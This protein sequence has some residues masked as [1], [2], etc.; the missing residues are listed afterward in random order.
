MPLSLNYRFFLTLSAILALSTGG[1]C[2][3]M[4]Q[5]LWPA[6]S[7]VPLWGPQS[8]AFKLIGFS[9]VYGFTLGWVATRCTRWA[10]RQH[11]VLPLHWHLKSQTLIDRLPARTFNRAF[12]LALASG[13]I[14]LIMVLLLDVSH[15]HMLPL[16]KFTVVAV[17][18]TT[19]LAVAVTVMA[20]YRALGDNV[21][22]NV[23]V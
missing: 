12:M 5:V 4:V 3:A 18:Y 10:L 1:L 17:L 7:L 11:K 14:A 19:L 16:G 2:F 23:R 15:L 6:D 8:M 21:W 22:R 9:V 13:T 20:V